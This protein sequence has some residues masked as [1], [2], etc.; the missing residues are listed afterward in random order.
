MLRASN[1]HLPEVAERAA[2]AKGEA[3][4]GGGREGGARMVELRAQRERSR[5]SSW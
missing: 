2:V 1:E 3:A 4:V 5:P